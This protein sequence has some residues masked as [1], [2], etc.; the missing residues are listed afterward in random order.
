MLIGALSAVLLSAC[1]RSKAEVDRWTY[2][3]D[4]GGLR[5][6]AEHALSR[7]GIQEFHGR[8]LYSIRRETHFVGA[9]DSG[10]ETRFFDVLPDGV[11]EAGRRS[12]S[13]IDVRGRRIES[14]DEEIA[15]PAPLILPRTLS[16][17]TRWSGAT[18]KTWTSLDAD[19]GSQRRRV[20]ER[21]SVAA[22]ETVTTPAGTFDCFVIETISTEQILGRPGSPAT[23]RI[24][25]WFSPELGWFV[26]ES[27]R[28]KIP[29]VFP[30][31][32][33]GEPQP[34]R[35]LYHT[36]LLTS[37][38]PHSWGFGPLGRLVA[39]VGEDRPR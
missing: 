19:A 18:T 9:S 27:V 17:G 31:A 28:G 20:T 24:K 16:V 23:K 36:L 33:T 13:T 22:R 14:A 35:E 32:G 5:K 7:G 29:S 11:H 34:K 21:S 15:D 25:R 1:S 30:A 38:P 4:L 39:F 8:R 2:E 3:V 6:N 12:R 37:A 26:K 10:S